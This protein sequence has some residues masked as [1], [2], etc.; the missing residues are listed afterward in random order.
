MQRKITSPWLV[1]IC[2][3]GCIQARK[4]ILQQKTEKLCGIDT[5]YRRSIYSVRL[6][7]GFGVVIPEEYGGNQRHLV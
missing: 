3:R 6:L 1:R 2:W 7:S 5:M 4:L